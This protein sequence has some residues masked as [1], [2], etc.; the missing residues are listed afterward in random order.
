MVAQL[1]S[2]RG[3]AELMAGFKSEIQD[4]QQKNLQ[5]EQENSNLTTEILN[6]KR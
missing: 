1:E 2:E 6:M 3:N 4:L 5:L